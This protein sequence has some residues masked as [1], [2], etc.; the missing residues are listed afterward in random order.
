MHF[1]SFKVGDAP[2]P[3]EGSAQLAW[4]ADQRITCDHNGF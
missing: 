4:P 2:S 3:S 1:T